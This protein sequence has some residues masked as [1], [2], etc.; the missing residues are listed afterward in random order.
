MANIDIQSVLA[1]LK[2]EAI[3]LAASSIKEFGNEAKSDAE[4]MVDT[5][6]SKLELWTGQLLS[7]KITPDDFADLVRGQEELIQMAA[8]KKAG[9]AAIKVDQLKKSLFQLVIN[10]IIGLI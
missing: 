2:N 7:N 4:K 6:K 8:L 1:S 3:S 10:T 9:V 5:L